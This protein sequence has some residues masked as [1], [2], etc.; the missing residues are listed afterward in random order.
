LSLSCDSTQDR[1]EFSSLLPGTLLSVL[2]RGH[3]GVADTLTTEGYSRVEEIV[4]RRYRRAAMILPAPVPGGIIVAVSPS[5]IRFVSMQDRKRR[6][7]KHTGRLL[8]VLRRRED[9]EGRVFPPAWRKSQLGWDA[10]GGDENLRYRHA[11]VARGMIA[12]S[13]SLLIRC[14][15]CCRPRIL[16]AARRKA[17]E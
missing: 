3:F 12:S 15:T 13:S 9:L 16:S 2:R 5:S 17:P 4:N 6:S 14:F 11:A 1:L 10:S 8:S 7:G